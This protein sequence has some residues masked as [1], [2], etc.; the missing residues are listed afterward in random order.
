M[1]ARLELAWCL[2]AQALY[3]AGRETAATAGLPHSSD[4]GG[5]DC[6]DAACA[7]NVFPDDACPGRAEALLRECLHQA[8]TVAQLSSHLED[9]HSAKL[10]QSLVCLSGGESAQAASQQRLFSRALSLFR[11]I[12]RP[13][14]E[15]AG[16]REPS[17][18]PCFRP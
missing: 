3:Q 7:R 9:A 5:P 10:L 17:A 1:Q 11:D 12:T 13:A 14:D 18:C 2:L 16:S 8:A 6:A 15:A 4:G